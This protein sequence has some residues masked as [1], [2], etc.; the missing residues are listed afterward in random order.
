MFRAVAI[1]AILC[2]T[3]A[4]QPTVPSADIT[5]T[6][7]RAIKAAD[8]A[9]PRSVEAAIKAIDMAVLGNKTAILPDLVALLARPVDKR[10][11]S[12]QVAAAAAVPKL[13]ADVKASVD[14]LVPVLDRPFPKVGAN[15]EQLG[16][17]LALAGAAVNALA[18]LEDPRAIV[19]T[20]RLI[21][22]APQL[23]QQARRAIVA[24]GPA[25]IVEVKKLL[26][27]QQVEIN[28]LFKAEKLDQSCDADGCQPVSLREFYAAILAG[29]LY[30][31][32]LAEDL[33]KLI[34]APSLPAY[35]FDGAPGPSQHQAAFEGLR[36]LG[37]PATAPA[38][39][40]I[41][42]DRKTPVEDRTLA[43]SAYAFVAT[44]PKG[45]AE[46]AA[47]AADNTAD[48]SLRQAAADSLARVGVTLADL[49]ANEGLAKRYLDAA[50]K[51]T[52]EVAKLNGRD[53]K[54][55]EQAAAAYLGYARM[56]QNHMARIEVGITCKAEPRCLVG[57]L[58]KTPAEAAA[59]MKPYLPDVDTWTAE[60][61]EALWEATVDRG[62]ID[63]SKRG[64]AKPEVLDKLLAHAG[65]TERIVRQAILIALAK[66]APRPCPA[67]VTKL[68]EVIEADRTKSLG[69]LTIETTLVR[70]YL[71]WG[72]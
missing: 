33:L 47:I 72:K 39:L 2:A 3:A 56:F 40:A 20:L 38:L 49:K 57:V 18:K 65:T 4:A 8:P 46:L 43:A 13:R 66:V 23:A 55:A 48:D 51:K 27:G 67:C 26:R 14:A 54:Q 60:H 45:S 25:S 59:R 30:D 15:D 71:R 1:A 19:P 22:R 52:A 37:N 63:L 36:R 11:I 64:T 7:R 31:P 12:A 21:Y 5:G 50:A 32:S 17:H 35:I 70:N 10:L 41:I 24:Y 69:D 16:L 28:Q 42:R 29:D 61:K 68:D 44:D 62:L 6:Y 58:D 34:K 9:D 53:K